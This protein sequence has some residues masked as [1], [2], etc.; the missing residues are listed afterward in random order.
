LKRTSIIEYNWL[1]ALILYKKRRKITMMN[2]YKGQNM[3]GQDFGGEDLQWENLVGQDLTGTNLADS[4]LIGA[5]LNGA[6]M[7]GAV[8]TGACLDFVTHDK[9][10]RWPQGFYKII[11]NQYGKYN[12]NRH[13]QTAAKKLV[14]YLNDVGVTSL[15][16]DVLEATFPSEYMEMDEGWLYLAKHFRDVG[17]LDVVGNLVE[18]VGIPFLGEPC[19]PQNEM[20]EHKEYG[21]IIF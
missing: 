9:M 18:E 4:N 13:W 8:L 21:G 10:T 12:A 14:L 11:L 1:V 20:M 6:D 7:E 19:K 5:N 17:I 15:S 2:N 3:R 16:D